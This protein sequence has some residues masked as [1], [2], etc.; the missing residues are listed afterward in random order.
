MG[1]YPEIDP[2]AVSLGPIQIHWYGMTYLAGLALAWWFAHRRSGKTGQWSSEQISDLIF[3]GALGIVLGGRLG[4]MLFYGWQDLVNDPSNLF[5]VWQGGM[6]F[7]GG[8]LG[9]F[10]ALYLFARKNKRTFF[11]VSDFI[12]P[13]VPLGLGCGRL[14]NFINAE[15]PGRV[16]DVPWAL[17]YPGDTVARHPSSLYQF[18]FEG[19]VLFTLLYVYSARSRPRMAVSGLFLLGYGIAR[20]FTEQ[21]REPDAHIQFIAFGWLTMGQALST[22]M[23]ICGLAFMW[24]AYSRKADNTR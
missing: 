11:E 3:F 20:I 7:H 8:M 2:V 19:P 14:G 12:A 4:Y 17:I 23:L 1:N 10:I 9:V 5:K 21:F 15:L 6:S 13:F 24:Y 16:T 22:P 18:F